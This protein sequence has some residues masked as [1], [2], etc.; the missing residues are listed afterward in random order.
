MRLWPEIFTKLQR[1]GLYIL[2]AEEMAQ[3]GMLLATKPDDPSSN[4]RSHMVEG[5]S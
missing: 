1:P 3:W 2:R 4:P 5:E